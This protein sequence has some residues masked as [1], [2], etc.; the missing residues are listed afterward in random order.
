MGW[1]IRTYFGPEATAERREYK[2]AQEAAELAQTQAEETLALE[3]E[4]TKQVT[5]GSADVAAAIMGT[6]PPAPTGLFG[7]DWQD[8]KVQ[9]TGGAVVLGAALAYRRWM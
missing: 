2:L 9:L 4:F 8:P 5:K 3:K 6:A 1:K 7:V